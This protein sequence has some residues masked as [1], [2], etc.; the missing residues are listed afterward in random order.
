MV[1]PD[2]EVD[3]KDEDDEDGHPHTRQTDLH[4][5]VPDK[6][7]HHNPEQQSHLVTQL[8]ATTSS[9]SASVTTAGTPCWWPGG[10]WLCKVEAAVCN[11]ATSYLLPVVQII[12]L[13]VSL[14]NLVNVVPHHPHHI[15]NLTHAHDNMHK[16][17]HIE[18]FLSHV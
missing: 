6:H 16:L 17:K 11:I 4:L 2:R 3:D 10:C 15:L 8:T 13:G 12:E 1:T 14:Q 9:S 7:H 5:Q 18:N